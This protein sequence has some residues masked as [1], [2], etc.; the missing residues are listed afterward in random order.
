M[1]MYKRRASTIDESKA[2]IVALSATTVRASSAA[3]AK[4]FLEY[5]RPGATT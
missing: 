5:L 1:T 2:R 4:S 3:A